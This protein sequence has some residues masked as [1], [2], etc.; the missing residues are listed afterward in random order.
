MMIDCVF[1]MLQVF[2]FAYSSNSI[3]L[4]LAVRENFLEMSEKME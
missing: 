3:C 2:D 4:Y 1:E